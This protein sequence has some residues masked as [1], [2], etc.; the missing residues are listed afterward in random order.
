MTIRKSTAQ[1]Q[2][3]M[4]WPPT[5]PARE[6]LS[7]RKALALMAAPAPAWLRRRSSA[8]APP[9]RPHP[10]S[11]PGRQSSVLAGA[12][13]LQS[14]D[15]AHRGRRGCLL[16]SVQ[17]AL[18][19]STRT[20]TSTPDLVAEVPTVENGGIS[21]D[22]LNWKVKL[23]DGV[24]WHDGTPFTAEDVKFTI[25][26]ITTRLPAG[27]RAGHELVRDITVVSPTEMTWRI[28]EAYAPYPAILSWTFIVPKHILGEEADPNT[29]PST[30]RP[31]RHRRVQVGR[32]R[33]R[34]P[35]HARW[36]DPD[37]FGEG[38]YLE[39]LIFKYIPDM[40]VLYT[41]FQ[42]GDVD[43]TGLQGITPDHYEEAKALAD[44]RDA[45]RCRS[46]SSR[47]SPSTR[48][49]ASSRTRR[50]ATRSIS[51]W[52]SRASST[53]LLR[54]ADADGSFLPQQSWAYN[55][56]LPKHASTVRR[57]PRR[58]STK[59]AGSRAATACATKNGVRLEF[60]DSTT[61]GNHI[62]E[63][64]QQLL[65]QTLGRDRRQDDASTTCRRR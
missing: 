55:P 14:A 36:A 47:T 49:A 2:R 27:R 8:A 63:Q 37:Y 5:R 9:W 38:P 12:D 58:S 15:A 4:T 6:D 61:A 42:T 28:G 62:R 22:G 3:R 60:T 40:T 65:Q 1:T 31:D 30:P 11:R 41:Q 24:K 48:A 13:G 17:R 43:Y 18:A 35:H 19:T 39:R 26:L 32:A 44:R 25:E 45:S 54:P 56:D 53:A 33:S 50:C 57:R 46:P 10:T 34:R 7:R 20:A 16:R 59:P 52:T 51:R 23:N 21:A 64:A 29:A